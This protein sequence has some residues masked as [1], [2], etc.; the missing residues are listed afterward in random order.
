MAVKPARA[1]IPIKVAGIK[2]EQD[3]HNP[4]HL[5]RIIRTN[6]QASVSALILGDRVG[7]VLSV[8]IA[9]QNA[10]VNLNLCYTTDIE[11]VDYYPVFIF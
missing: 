9:K 2:P 8:Q 7:A 1:R 10:R 4:V 11:S 6:S 3:R 5:R